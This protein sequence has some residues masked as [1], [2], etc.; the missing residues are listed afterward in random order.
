MTVFSGNGKGRIDRANECYDKRKRVI[1][2][3]ATG[4]NII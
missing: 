1:H 3:D 4:W 2:G